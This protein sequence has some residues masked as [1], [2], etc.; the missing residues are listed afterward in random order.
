MGIRDKCR[1]ISIHKT[2][3]YALIETYIF[4]TNVRL[5]RMKSSSKAL[6]SILSA[7]ALSIFLGGCGSE[8]ASYSSVISNAKECKEMIATVEDMERVGSRL[9]SS[10]QSAYQYLKE[11]PKNSEA[12]SQVISSLVAV[13]DND[14]LIYRT[15]FR[16]PQCFSGN[17]MNSIEFFYEN[18]AIASYNAKTWK[19]EFGGFE[20]EWYP[21][22]VTLFTALT[23]DWL[24]RDFKA[25]GKLEGAVKASQENN[26]LDS[27]N[28]QQESASLPT[29]VKLS[30]TIHSGLALAPDGGSHWGK[31]DGKPGY[32]ILP[33]SGG[34][35]IYYSGE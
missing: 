15:A 27:G 1:R 12:N 24:P 32:C 4:L 6:F 28:N 20:E 11:N 19:N 29:C 7:L 9:H 2:L 14:Q 16:F 18:T 35:K 3:I 34:A 25:D 33:N 5:A 17:S 8:S 31:S 30:N 21:E 26:D 23:K 13:Y 22:Y 10:Y